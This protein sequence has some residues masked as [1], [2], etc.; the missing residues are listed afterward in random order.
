MISKIRFASAALELGIG[1]SDVIKFFRKK[2]L[3]FTKKVKKNI[4]SKLIDIVIFDLDFC[5]NDYDRLPNKRINYLVLLKWLSKS[6][7]EDYSR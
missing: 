7:T 2:N 3:M 6:I 5:K 1:K 4:W